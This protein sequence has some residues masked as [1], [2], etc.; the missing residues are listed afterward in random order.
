M[1]DNITF[2]K[3]ERI[4]KDFVQVEI[5]NIYIRNMLGND[6]VNIHALDDIFK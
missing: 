2:D 6:F 5:K 3:E 4:K 1:I